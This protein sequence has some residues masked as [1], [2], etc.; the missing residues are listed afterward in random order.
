M[1]SSCFI[2]HLA[3][4]ENRALQ[5][6]LDHFKIP[7]QSRGRTFYAMELVGETGE[8]IN[9]CK[10][11]VRTSLAHRK[12]R[13]ARSLIPEEAAD[14]LVALMLVKLAAGDSRRAAP[15]CPT[16]VP[17]NDVDWLHRCLSS[18]A[19]K[20]AELYARE[21][22]V[23]SVPD[24]NLDDYAAIVSHLLLVASF[25]EFHL[26]QA[27]HDKLDRIIVKVEAGYYD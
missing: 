13:Q 11:F 5:I 3:L 16:T 4:L 17:R 9:A 1:S 20:S 24:F 7:P 21:S 23:S 22:V 8:L 2:D 12:D 26:E 15:A 10:K 19:L 14:S 6:Q 25:F 18:L 27:V